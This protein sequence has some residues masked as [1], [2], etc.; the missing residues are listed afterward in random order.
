[1]HSSRTPSGRY[2][3]GNP[4]YRIRVPLEGSSVTET[5]EEDSDGESTPDLSVQ[6]LFHGRDHGGVRLVVDQKDHVNSPGGYSMSETIGEGQRK[7]TQ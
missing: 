3:V 1:M 5:S 7:E 2:Q 4:L 6:G